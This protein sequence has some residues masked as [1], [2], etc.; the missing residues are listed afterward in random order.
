M[1]L[2]M[3]RG[4]NVAIDILRGLHFLHAKRIVHMDLK[5]PN[6]LLTRHGQA[7]LADVGLAKVIRDR[8]YIT[9]VSVIGAP[10]CFSPHQRALFHQQQMSHP[11]GSRELF[12]SAS[13]RPA[14]E[15]S[16]IYLPDRLR[17]VGHLTHRRT[18]N[19]LYAG[20]FAWAAPEVL[21]NERCTEK[22]DIYSFGIILWWDPRC[23]LHSSPVTLR[24][25]SGWK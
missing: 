22:A 2:M 21:T 6:I 11:H 19:T 17:T 7:K 12:M 15:L 10:A 24:Q 3:R 9:Q 8:N 1:R 23:L 16:M 5:S 14:I 20:T 25:A 18:F 4:K 13:R